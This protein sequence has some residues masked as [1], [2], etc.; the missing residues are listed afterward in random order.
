MDRGNI[1]QKEKVEPDMN[2]TVNFDDFAGVVPIPHYPL[3]AKN[4]LARI[5]RIGEL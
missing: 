2:R 4:L 1:E 5:T 3:K